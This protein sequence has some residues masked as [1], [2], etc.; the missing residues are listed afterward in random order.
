MARKL[1][2]TIVLLAVSLAA[3]AQTRSGTLSGAV[4]N[5]AGGP[6]MG[7]AVKGLLGAGEVATVFTDAQGR[8]TAANLPAGTYIVRA[9]AAAFLPSLRENVALKAGAH[10]VVNLALSTLFEAVQLL[11]N[12]KR[13]ADDEEDWKWTLR[14]AANRPILRLVGDSAVLVSKESPAGDPVLKAKVAFLAGGAAEGF[15]STSDMATAFSLERSMFS[16]GTVSVRGNVGYGEANPSAVVRA[17]YARDL[18]TSH[19]EVAFTMRRFATPDGMLRGGSMQALSLA[20]SDRASIA[21]FLDVMYG[22]EFQSIQVV[23]HVNA[24]RPFGAADLH[25]GP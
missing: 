18:G 12:R 19:P 17:S 8:Y 22:G 11:P 2:P 5:S 16:S 25:F 1:I 13:G 15:G 6:Q 3:S 20:M 9:S 14:S 7:A 21:D 23:G 24:F 10:L 4:K